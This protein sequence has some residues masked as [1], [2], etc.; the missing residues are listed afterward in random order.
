VHTGDHDFPL[1]ETITAITL[2]GLLAAL[3][4]GSEQV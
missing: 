3:R 4:A 1:D 2:S